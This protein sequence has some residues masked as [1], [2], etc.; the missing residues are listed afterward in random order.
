MTF[1]IP[2]QIKLKDG[3]TLFLE[4]VIDKNAD[5][6]HDQDLGVAAFVSA[7]SETPSEEVHEHFEGSEKIA[8][9]YHNLIDECD[10]QP[11]RAG[12]LI[13]IR[14]YLE[15]E[16]IGWMGLEADF[17]NKNNTYISTFVLD[18][19]CEGKG[20]GEKMISSIVDH[21]LP[22]TSELNLVVRKI[23]HKA[24]GFFQRFG[25]STATDINHPYVDN[26][27]HCMFMRWRRHSIQ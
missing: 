24:L 15:K 27:Q 26:P 19:V 2:Y 18:P 14:A 11:F 3:Q 25:F 7:Y 17:I 21:W 16:F 10:I 20:I 12:K 1:S 6:T 22:E 5:L 8:D 13:W 23:N 4:R 9:Y